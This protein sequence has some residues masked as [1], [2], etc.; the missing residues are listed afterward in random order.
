MGKLEIYGAVLLSEEKIISK[1]LTFL[2]EHVKKDMEYLI[3]KK[4]R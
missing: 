4:D 3:K 1:V 2:T